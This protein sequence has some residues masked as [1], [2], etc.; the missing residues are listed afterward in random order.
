[1]LNTAISIRGDLEDR[2]KG[3]RRIQSKGHCDKV[4]GTIIAEAWHS[5][6][7]S[8]E[9]NMHKQTFVIYCGD[10]EGEEQYTVH[11]RRAQHGNDKDSLQRFLGSEFEV[12]LRA[13]TT[14]ASRPNGVGGS[15][16]LLRQY[17][18]KCIK[19]RKASECDCKICTLADILL[20][21][22]HGAR[23]GWRTSWRKSADG[24]LHRPP[25]CQCFVCGD[26]KRFGAFM[27]V[28]IGTQL[29]HTLYVTR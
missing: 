5:E 28:S 13:A 25:P 1:M 23:H 4:D 18:C 29:V 19:Q 7:L 6:L 26:A 10:C 24:T 17:K 3:W 16:K 14:T 21:R 9:D 22:W 12:R 20:R 2:A 27:E 15:L 8:C 11:E